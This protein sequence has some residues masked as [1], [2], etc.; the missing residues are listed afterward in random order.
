[1]TF[2]LKRILLKFIRDAKKQMKKVRKEEMNN[3]IW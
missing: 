3:T 1:M 2:Q